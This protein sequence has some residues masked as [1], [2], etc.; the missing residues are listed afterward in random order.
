MNNKILGNFAE[1]KACLFLKQAGYQI[2]QRNF[3]TKLGEIDIIAK[4]KDDLCFVEVKARESDDYGEPEES[5]DKQKKRH[6]IKSA[7]M[8]INS[9][10]I[11]FTTARFDVI[12][13]FTNGKIEHFK[14]AFEAEGVY[15]E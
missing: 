8:F 7:L 5:I 4:E 1:D 12:S 3:R 13:V 15:V 14:D 9:E 10:K 2:I 11:K 6:I